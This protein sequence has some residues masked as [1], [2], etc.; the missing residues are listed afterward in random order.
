MKC[1]INNFNKNYEYKFISNSLQKNSLCLGLCT[2]RIINNKNIF[3]NSYGLLKFINKFTI[4]WNLNYRNDCLLGNLLFIR[5]KDIFDF[6]EI[7]NSKSKNFEFKK[8]IK[9]FN[10]KKKRYLTDQIYSYLFN[11]IDEFNCPLFGFLFSNLKQINQNE[12]IVEI[13][14]NFLF[15]LYFNTKNISKLN[16]I[17]EIETSFA[18]FKIYN[19]IKNEKIIFLY[20]FLDCH[21]SHQKNIR[22]LVMLKNVA[23]YFRFEKF[24][25]R[26]KKLPKIYKFIK[27]YSLFLYRPDI[28][29]RKKRFFKKSI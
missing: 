7:R 21:E 8:K 10:F 11:W 23:E 13:H 28:K 19:T 25:N 5:N 16:N 18:S 17:V 12:I 26:N 27:K 1:D 15:A 22:T 9:I 29:C 2:Q 24:S 6:K 20:D 4:I 14:S 3:V